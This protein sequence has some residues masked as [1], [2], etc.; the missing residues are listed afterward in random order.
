[1]AI[2]AAVAG[3]T[4]ALA[5]SLSGATDPLTDL[6]VGA[7]ALDA[8]RYPAAIATLKGLPQRLPKL[9]DYA[10]WFLASAQSSMKDYA[11]VPATLETVFKQSPASPLV[12]RSALLAAGALTQNNQPAAALDLLRKYYSVI[13][14]P[15]GDLAM[16]AAFAGSGDNL[17]AAI[18]YQRVY[19][20]FPVSAE[21]AQA[22][23][24]I[25][26][27]PISTKSIRPHCPP[28]CWV[29]RSSS[30]MPA[31]PCVLARNWKPWSQ[32]SVARSAISRGSASA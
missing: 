2:V 23:T 31:K 5:F 11:V 3:V 13:S 27:R 15:K 1:V 18:Y 17:S 24:E 7:D 16:A 32:S 20:G 9:A 21:A 8:G 4:F 28:P 26:S 30:S 14:Q 6:K 29:A 22:A 19:Y 25:G 12:P 10:A